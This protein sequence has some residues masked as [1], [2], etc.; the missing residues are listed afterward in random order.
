MTIPLDE[1][2]W[3]DIVGNP[4][5]F[6]RFC[7]IN[8]ASKMAIVD[9]EFW[10]HLIT[11]LRAFEEHLQVIVLKSK[12]IGVSYILAFYALWKALTNRAFNCLVISAGEKEAAQLLDKCKFAYQNLP[13]MFKAKVGKWSETEITFSELGSKI[14]ALP[15]TETPGLGSTAS[16]VIMDEW[17]FHRYPES[18]FSTAEPTI[19]AGGKLI[20]VSTVDKSKPDSLFKELYKQAKEGLNQ[21]FPV[22]LPWDSRPDRGK[23]WYEVEKTHYIGRE[24]LF[25]ENYPATEQQALS[26]LSSLSLF[27]TNPSGGFTLEDVLNGCREPSQILNNFCHIYAKWRP[28]VLYVAGADVASGTGGDY[29]SC[30]V[31]GKE[32]SVAEVVAV[33]HTNNIGPDQFGYYIDNLCKD[34]KNPLLAVEYNSMGIATINELVRLGYKNLF[35]NDKMRLRP[36]W[37]TT[38]YNRDTSLIELAIATAKGQFITRFK[39]MVLE[40]FNFQRGKNSDKAEAVGGHDDLVMASMIAWQMC[41]NKTAPMAVDRR[42]QLGKRR[43][44]G[45]Y[46]R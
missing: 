21:F 38:K 5:E 31:L 17:D 9:F 1:L 25:D 2:V 11:L 16:L 20:G 43:T 39:P 42:P 37:V 14:M 18:D 19:S 4:A 10:P 26:P 34:Y 27:N 46:R 33:I 36:G 40:M 23:E 30:V 32:N 44:G 15:S 6:M 29:Q 45:M 8:D 7:K 24:Y 35:Y 41:K 3:A 28:G 12:Q 13:D 22:F